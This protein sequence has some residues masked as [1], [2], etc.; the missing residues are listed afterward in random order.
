MK[1]ILN[2]GQQKTGSTSLQ[3]FWE[4]NRQQLR[5]KGVL[6]PKSLG[7]NKQVKIFAQHEQIQDPNSALVRSFV[8][9]RDR[10]DFSTVLFSEENLYVCKAHIKEHIKEF[11]LQHFTE[12][13]IVVYLRRQEEHIPSHYQQAVKGRVGLPLDQWIKKMVKIK[14][15]YYQYDRVL[16]VWAT[17]FP[18]AQIRVVPFSIVKEQSLYTHCLSYLGIDNVGLNMDVPS[19]NQSWDRRSIELFRIVNFIAKEQP[20]LVGED[21]RIDLRKYILEDLQQN[22]GDKITLSQ[23]QLDLIYESTHESNE[24]L[25]NKYDIDRRHHSYLLNPKT[26][27]P[28]TPLLS[29]EE[30]FAM[31]LGYL[32]KRRRY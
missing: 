9:E 21:M 20:E 15:Q 17:L 29:N 18:D 11:L 7:V 14:N 31:I 12:I 19:L 24:R 4:K 6:Y 16:D 13:E 5:D 22:K 27:K 32:K 1:A 28:T 10:S 8:K 2:I 23:E 3:Y 26:A 30:L 25:I